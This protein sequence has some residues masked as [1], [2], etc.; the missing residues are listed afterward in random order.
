[1]L[2]VLIR[3]TLAILVSQKNGFFK[4]ILKKYLQVRAAHISVEMISGVLV[5]RTKLV[6]IKGALLRDLLEL[7]QSVGSLT[8]QSTCRKGWI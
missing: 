5:V 6:F 2:H 7:L 1:M 4:C 3:I 8:W